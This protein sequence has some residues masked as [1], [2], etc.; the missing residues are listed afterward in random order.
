LPWYDAELYRLKG[1]LMLEPLESG[2]PSPETEA[3][4]CFI[5]AIDIARRQGA[6]LF[7]LRA[8]MSL[9]RLRMRQGKKQEARMQFSVAILLRIEALKTSPK[10]PATISRHLISMPLFSMM[11]AYENN[12]PVK[13]TL[14]PSKQN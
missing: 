8:V 12:Y 10:S 1:E 9:A 14:C 5:R 6:R 3:K 4:A 13:V 11:Y 2:T 7:E